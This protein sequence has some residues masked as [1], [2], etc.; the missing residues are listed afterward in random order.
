MLLAILFPSSQ[1]HPNPP[2]LGHKKP[3]NVEEILH[4][5]GN[6]LVWDKVTKKI[7]GE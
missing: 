4:K 3:R 7:N 2:T 6:V 1:Y 5:Y